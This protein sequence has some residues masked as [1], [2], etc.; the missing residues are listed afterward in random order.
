MHKFRFTDSQVYVFC[1]INSSV[2]AG[3]VEFLP[4]YRINSGMAMSMV[5]LLY[6]V[7]LL[8]NTGGVSTIKTKSQF[9]IVY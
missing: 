5:L 9:N 4:V 8:V 7:R 2:H 3:K 6:L 1:A